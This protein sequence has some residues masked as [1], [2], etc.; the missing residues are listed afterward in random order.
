MSYSGRYPRRKSTNRWVW[1]CIGIAILFLWIMI[2]IGTM[3]NITNTSVFATFRD[4]Y[5]W[6]ITIAAVPLTILWAIM[7]RHYYGSPWE[8][9]FTIIGIGDE[10]A[11]VNQGSRLEL[12]K[13]QKYK[14][15]IILKCRRVTRLNKGKVFFGVGKKPRRL[16]LLIE[17]IR[18]KIR[19]KDLGFTWSGLINLFFPRAF[20]PQDGKYPIQIQGI[21]LDTT[22]G[23]EANGIEF[24][25]SPVGDLVWRIDYSPDYD[26]PINRQIR[27]VAEIITYDNKWIGSIEFS[28]DIV[29]PDTISEA[30]VS[31]M[32][33][34]TD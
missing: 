24:K 6:I 22:E 13:G 23:R 3:D 7:R 10:C 34:I 21:V 12:R 30:H 33:V 9:N 18:L 5:S 15:S 29:E 2:L 27:F 20:E 28:S 31:R 32:I 26:V 11:G 14:V 25:P 4:W 16:S 19:S 8:M 1:W 17:S